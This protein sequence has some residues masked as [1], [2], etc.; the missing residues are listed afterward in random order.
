MKITL[1]NVI[2]SFIII[3]N[4]VIILSNFSSYEGLE[5]RI[6]D[7][8]PKPQGNDNDTIK[9][10]SS[11]VI[12]SNLTSNVSNSE[13]PSS[14]KSKSE[15]PL[16]NDSNETPLGNDFNETPGGNNSKSNSETPM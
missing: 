6:N 4:L 11:N 13:T 7:S 10:T 15:T 9:P 8:E 12:S 1:K 16:G 5:I 2:L 14:N 3:F